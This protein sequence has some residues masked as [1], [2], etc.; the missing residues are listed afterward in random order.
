MN[1]LRTLLTFAAVP[2]LLLSSGCGA[3][4][5]QP[6]NGQIVFTDGTPV[7]GLEGGRVTAQSTSTAPDAKTPSGAIDTQGRFTLGTD[8]LADGAPE[9]EYQ[10]LI[11]V[12]ESTG[13]E[14][15]PQVIDPKHTRPGGFAKTFTVQKGKNEWQVEVERAPMR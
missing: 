9:G 5:Y 8:G 3:K 12:P 2:V 11:T 1:I 7:Q 6:V 13:D 14:Q 15:L 10:L 4:T